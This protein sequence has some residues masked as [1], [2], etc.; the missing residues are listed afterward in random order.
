[1]IFDAM[2]GYHRIDPLPTQEELDRYYLTEF[3]ERGQTFNDSSLA[4]K[5]AQREFFDWKHADVAATCRELLGSASP[6][7]LLDVGCGYGHALE[8]FARVGWDVAGVEPS[9]DACRVCA[10]K[11]LAVTHGPIEQGFPD[12][13]R[14]FDVVVLLNVLEH[15]RQPADTLR[16]VRDTALKP[17]GVLVVDVPNEFNPFQVVADQTY[18]LGQ[19]WITPPGHLNYFNTATLPG[20]LTTLGYRVDVVES[21]FPLE[22]FLLMG[23]GYVGNPEVG[24]ACHARRCAFERNLRAAGQ[25]SL[26]RRMYQSFAALGV[27]RQVTAFARSAPNPMANSG[28]CP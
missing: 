27:G 22:L 25:V 10:G 26:L 28:G 7:T 2:T 9:A 4:V 8:Y 12:L 21:S 15:L 3:Y 13:G 18:G 6:L 17:G 20:L 16:A 24:A 1:M 14:R 23:E 5:E 11:G 19:W